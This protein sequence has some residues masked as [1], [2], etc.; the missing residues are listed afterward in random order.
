MKGLFFRKSENKF[1]ESLE[2]SHK[3]RTAHSSTTSEFFAGGG[4]ELLKRI[5]AARTH[6]LPEYRYTRK[7]RSASPP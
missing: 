6:K 4:G 3:G 1:Q 7:V 5:S 2:R